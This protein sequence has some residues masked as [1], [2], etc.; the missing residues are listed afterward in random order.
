MESPAKAGSLKSQMKAM[1]A[2]CDDQQVQLEEANAQLE[3]LTGEKV[4]RDGTWRCRFARLLDGLPRSDAAT[5]TVR[6]PRW[7]RRSARPVGLLPAARPLLAWARR[8]WGRRCRQ[9]PVPTDSA[10]ERANPGPGPSAEAECARFLRLS[11]LLSA[12][13]HVHTYTYTS[14]CTLSPAVSAVRSA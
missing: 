1:Q 13:A 10:C 2:L 7:G 5:R 14:L 11:V 4:S 8:Q 6:Q 9:T 12:H 3:H